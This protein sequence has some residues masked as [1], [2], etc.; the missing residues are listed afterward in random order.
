MPLTAYGVAIGTFVEFHRDPPDN[1]GRFYH[2]H[3]TIQTPA[4]QFESAIDVD[5]PSGAG[6]SIKTIAPLDPALFATVRALADGW[7]PLASTGASG[8]LDYVRGE[9]L[10]DRC[11][12]PS[13]TRPLR[14][15]ALLHRWW[16][17]GLDRLRHLLCV[18]FRR[19]RGWA[20]SSGDAALTVLEGS[21]PGCRRVFLFGQHYDSGLGVHDVHMNQGDPAGSPWYASDGVWQDG[22]VVVENADGTL[23]AW[24]VRFNTQS[25]STD[26]QGHPV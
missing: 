9:L 3:L 2:G 26:A 20:T 25:L 7:H 4:G 15:P 22:G 8:A 24:L 18:L 21:L 17:D 23:A 1:F 16:L 14:P 5:T 10:L 11:P 12:P 6:V 19:F 13:W